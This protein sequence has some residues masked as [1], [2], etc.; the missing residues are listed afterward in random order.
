MILVQ[1]INV[2]SW[3]VRK[4]T[5]PGE[6]QKRNTLVSF[7]NRARFLMYILKNQ[8]FALKYTLKLSLIKI[9]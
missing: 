7:C 1:L 8:L 2:P 6:T 3:S 5:L 4:E 9:N